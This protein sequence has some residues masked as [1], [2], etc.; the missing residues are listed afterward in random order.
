VCDLNR[1]AGDMHECID[2]YVAI[3]NECRDD[4]NRSKAMRTRMFDYLSGR[5]VEHGFKGD[6][7][8][9]WSV[10]EIDVILNTQGLDAWLEW[11]ES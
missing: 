6:R 5:L 4:P 2:T 3:G 1:L 7:D 11:Q 8:A 10:L 9:M